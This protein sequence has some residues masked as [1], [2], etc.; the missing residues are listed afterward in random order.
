MHQPP[1]VLVVD[2]EHGVRETA[3]A[4][5]EHL[6]LTVCEAWNAEAA[7]L[8]LRSRAEIAVL[9]T[10]VR[11]PGMGGIDLAAAARK[12]RPDLKVIVTSGYT[13]DEVELD[14]TM[15]FLRKPWRLADL[16][17]ALSRAG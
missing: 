14:E 4:V 16:E 7:L 15:I 9:F 13:G 1:A 6:G 10:D 5:F 8:M 3:V 2:D 17:E 11:L 12:I